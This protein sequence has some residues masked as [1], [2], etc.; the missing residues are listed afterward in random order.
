M[1]CRAVH[2]YPSSPPTTLLPE[3][4]THAR[5]AYIQQHSSACGSIDVDVESSAASRL[6]WHGMAWHGMAEGGGFVLDHRW[7]DR[8]VPIDPYAWRQRNVS[9]QLSRLLDRFPV[10][11]LAAFPGCWSYP[12]SQAFPTPSSLAC[13]QPTLIDLRPP[14]VFLAL[15]SCRRRLVSSRAPGSGSHHKRAY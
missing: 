6:A 9:E 10:I 3:E 11:S 14:G 13:C 2:A 8:S 4:T 15:D 12:S 7:L 5:A 1:P